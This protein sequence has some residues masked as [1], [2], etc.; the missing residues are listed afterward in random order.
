NK[1]RGDLVLSA[2]T[3][4]VAG[5][6]DGNLK[7]SAEKYYL[8]PAL[9][10]K[11]SRQIESWNSDAHAAEWLKTISLAGLG[12]MAAFKIYHLLVLWLIFWAMISFFPQ[13]MKTLQDTM[14]Q[15]FWLSSI[16]GIVF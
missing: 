8:D 7:I 9:K 15:R 2:E 3:M 1:V 14:T 5:S 16:L 6:V 4:R 10:V 12:F 13:V 11:G